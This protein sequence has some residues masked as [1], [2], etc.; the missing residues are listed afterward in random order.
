[1]TKRVQVLLATFNGA[2]HL[3]Q[4]LDSLIGQMDIEIDLLV[5]DDGSQDGT[6]QI[7]HSYSKSFKNFKLLA[8]PQSGPAKNFFFLLKNANMAD[9][10]YFAFADQDDVWLPT[11]LRDSIKRI[12]PFNN[13]AALTFARVRTIQKGK[14]AGLVLPKKIFPELGP[15]IIFENP[16]RGCTIVFNKNLASLVSLLDSS[17][18]IMHDWWLLLIAYSLGKVVPSNEVEVMYR[19]HQDNAIGLGQKSLLA[20]GKNF[21]ASGVN[22]KIHDQILSLE[23]EVLERGIKIQNPNLF[24]WHSFLHGNLHRR[25]DIFGRHF[26]FRVSKLE[27]LILRGYFLLTSFEYLDGEEA[28][29]SHSRSL[30]EHQRHGRHL[31]E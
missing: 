5:S 21:I 24:E 30:V 2:Q 19:I 1:M 31:N 16:A 4:L 3:N 10:S 13:D 22:K 17:K 9:N 20:R 26:R 8:G 6:I 29:L 12:L 23:A 14:R 28:K 27:D 25:F 7:I 15:M 18:S 11:H